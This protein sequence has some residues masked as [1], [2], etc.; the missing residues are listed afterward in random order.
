MEIKIFGLSDLEYF[1][2]PVDGHLSHKNEYSVIQYT[3]SQR[4]V[5]P[6]VV[7]EAKDWIHIPID[8]LDNYN[9]SSYNPPQAEDIKAALDFAE[10]KQKL[11]VA[12]SAGI[13]RS[14]STAYLINAREKNSA[15]EGLKILEIGRHHPNR[16]IVYIGS[17]LLKNED[18]WE[19]YVKWMRDYYGIDPSRSGTW[20]DS[21]TIAGMEFDKVK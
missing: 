17:R 14:S 5:S 8:D 21:K 3:P 18:I 11:I 20:P 1:L 16:L 12:C 9:Y 7:T 4:K 6:F 15:T 10:G 19:K 2:T 13:S